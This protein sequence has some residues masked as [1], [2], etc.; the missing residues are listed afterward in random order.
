MSLQVESENSWLGVGRGGLSF[1][2][3][4][5]WLGAEL[6]EEVEG[7][8]AMA[9][10]TWVHVLGLLLSHCPFPEPPFSHL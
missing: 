1:S 8:G 6:E 10:E 9:W 4:L 7:W 5:G 3:A 2:S